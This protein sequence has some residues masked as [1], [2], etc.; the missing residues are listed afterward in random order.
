MKTQKKRMAIH[1]TGLPHVDKECATQF[2]NF[3]NGLK[4]EYDIS[5]FG[6]F[7]TGSTTRSFR[8]KN[9]DAQLVQNYG[10]F[11]DLVVE[12]DKSPDVLPAATQIGNT[13]LEPMLTLLVN[14]TKV[15]ALHYDKAFD[16]CIFMQTD[17]LLVADMQLPDCGNF[18]TML[19]RT[20]PENFSEEEFDS[21]A[22]C[23]MD[24][25]DYLLIGSSDIV[26]NILSEWS[27]FFESYAL[28]D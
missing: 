10:S 21:E 27:Y 13:E 24:T 3:V 28:I 16:V 7:Y 14:M 25:R 20:D 17:T 5:L 2:R 6:Y 1:F 23:K 11:K 15:K 4:E 18:I 19:S 22:F 12:H 26:E 8:S 9:V